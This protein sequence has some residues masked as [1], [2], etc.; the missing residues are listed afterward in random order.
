L[1]YRIV[2]GIFPEKLKT[3]GYQIYERK[4]EEIM[5]FF[6]GSGHHWNPRNRNDYK[7]YCTM[8]D[9]KKFHG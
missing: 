3:P 9:G 8:M 4:E 5:L 2:L 1:T 6:T 7:F